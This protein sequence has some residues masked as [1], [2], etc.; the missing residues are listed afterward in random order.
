MNRAD[1]SW[2]ETRNQIKPLNRST[3]RS[4]RRKKKLKKYFLEFLMIFL[5]VAFGFFAE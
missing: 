5:A 4:T 3:S 1:T 2:T